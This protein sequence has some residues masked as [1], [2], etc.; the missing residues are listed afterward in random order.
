MSIAPPNRLYI[1]F[2]VA[3][4]FSFLFRVVREDRRTV[5]REF[6]GGGGRSTTTTTTTTIS[7]HSAPSLRPFVRPLPIRGCSEL[8]E[9]VEKEEEEGQEKE[10][11]GYRC[12]DGGD[13]G[14]AAQLGGCSTKGSTSSRSTRQR[15]TSHQAREAK[16]PSAEHV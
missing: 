14:D 7:S 8:C 6:V 5:V 12:D 10:S 16:A 2:D 4:V 9:E 1:R 11:L 13:S 15:V 3:L